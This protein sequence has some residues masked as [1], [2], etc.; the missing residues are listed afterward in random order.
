LGRQALHVQA[1]A[2]PGFRARGRAAP[3]GKG[4]GKDAPIIQI[5]RSG[6]RSSKAADRLQAAGYTKV[7]S[8]TDGFEG[9][10]ASDGEKLGQ[11]VVNGSKNA[12]LPWTYKLD[13]AK[14][15]FPR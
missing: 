8:V 5:C 12:N 15:Y 4:L 11:R 1:R 6:N 9:D 10:T 13:K 14:M 7:Y 2:Q 3:Q